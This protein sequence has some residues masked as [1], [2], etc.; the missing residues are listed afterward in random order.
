MKKPVRLLTL[1]LA[2]L[3]S[4]S[5]F[6]SCNKDTNTPKD[7]GAS[8]ETQ[9]SNPDDGLYDEDGYLKDSL[10][11]T[12][13]FNSEF[14]IYT[15]NEM[16]EWE[17]CEEQSATPTTVEQVLWTREQNVEERFGVDIVRVY[18]DG[19][20]TPRTTFISKLSNS[21]LGNDHEYDLVGQYTPC[22]GLAATSG[23]YENLADNAYIDFS[24]PWW[25]SSITE[26]ATIGDKLYFAT[27]DI[28]PTLV[29]NVQCMFV[30]TDLY[31]SYQLAKDVNGK[32]IYE[33]VE[34]YEWTM[35]TMMKLALNKVSV[36]QGNYGIAFLND[37]VPDAF[38]YGAGFT[39]VTNEDG[40]MSLSS[41]LSNNL[42]INFFDQVQDLFTDRYDDVDITGIDPFQQNK[43][44]FYGGDLSGSQTLSTEGVKFSVLPMPML[45]ADQQ[46][47]MTCASFWVT[48]YGIPV[49][50]KDFSMSSVILEALASEAYRTVSDEIYYN[51]FQMRYN[52]E[53]ENS[54][55]MFDIVSD[56]VVFDTA[57]FFPDELGLYAQFRVGVCDTAGNWST[58]YGG[59]K[60]AWA[61]KITDLYGKIG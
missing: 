6:A 58:T 5:L 56:S 24:K 38:F 10:P 1:L 41:Q 43:A 52:G 8:D 48:M 36:D 11:E 12:Y 34:D 37:V 21:V 50:V 7:T 20:W 29:R 23:L 44:I 33:V 57:R 55:R 22:A 60:E 2:G 3:L 61:Q 19:S 9:A 49:D 17:W 53:N 46:E 4:V 54:A 30:N 35:E 39:Y 31:E 42:L 45:N 26:T 14:K 18:E 40:I 25:P 51:L 28:T 32:S 47:Y 15:W 16:K 13:N 59:N 27:G